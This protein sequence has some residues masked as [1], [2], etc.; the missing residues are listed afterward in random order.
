MGRKEADG[1]TDSG[2]RQS[3]HHRDKSEVPDKV[4]RHCQAGEKYQGCSGGWNRDSV[5]CGLFHASAGDGL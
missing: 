1:R 2:D 5:L 3:L 4:Q